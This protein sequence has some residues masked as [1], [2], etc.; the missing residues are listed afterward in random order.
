MGL[1]SSE[2]TSK[3]PQT[4]VEFIYT[5]IFRFLA[6]ILSHTEFESLSYYHVSRFIQIM[7]KINGPNPEELSHFFDKQFTPMSLRQ[8]VCNALDFNYE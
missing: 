6:D 3:A 2:K 1:V 8:F 5:K 4:D 7:V